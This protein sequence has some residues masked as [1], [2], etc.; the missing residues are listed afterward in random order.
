MLPFSLIESRQANP[1]QVVPRRG[2][3]GEKYPPIG[4]FYLSITTSLFYLSLRVPGKGAPSTFPNR[5]PM[6]SDTPSPEPLLNF[7]FNHSNMSAGVPK[8]EPSY[9]NM[10]KNIWSPSTELHA[11][12]R[13]TYSGVRPGPPRGSLTTLLSVP[14]CHA[15][16]GT[17][18]STLAWVD[19]SPFSQHVSRQG[20]TSTTL[21]ASHVTLCR[22]EYESTIP[23]GT[24][25][26]L[27][28]WEASRLHLVNVFY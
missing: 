16:F 17:I 6:G 14:Q 8:K 19:L 26:G 7:S 11:D 18:P 23:R 15:A 9:I 21:T 20:I 5:V 22:V 10:R 1:L 2:P 3:Y 27:D 13:P 28:L 4:H 12:G 25:E 24:D